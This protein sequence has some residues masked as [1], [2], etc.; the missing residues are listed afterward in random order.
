MILSAR[1]LT[2]GYH[3]LVVGSQ[4]DVSLKTG[5]ALAL[6][7]PN[8]GGKTTLLKTLLGLLRPISGEVRLGDRPLASY[9]ARERARRIA[10]VPQ[11]HAATFAFTVET[12][13]LMGRT[14]HGTLFS[15][16][17]AADRAVA[18][19]MLERFG[20]VHLADRP[21]TMISGGERQLTLLARALAQEPQFVVLD[22][23]TASLDFG[24]QG[25]VMREIGALVASGHGVLFTTHDPNHAMR[26]ANRAFLL[27]QGKCIAEGDVR[28]VLERTQLEELYGAKIVRIQDRGSDQTAFLPG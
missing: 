12:V 11:S 21:Y 15:R 3:D 1:D 13:V 27:R 18:L 25:R 20:I 22:E 9:T 6:L 24:N 23:P 16:P 19:R 17:S 8:G 28:A 7:G 26:A 14:A 2:I 10:Y 4:L 5:E